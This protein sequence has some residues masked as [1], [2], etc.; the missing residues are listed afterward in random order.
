MIKFSFCKKY[1]EDFRFAIIGKNT[2]LNHCFGSVF[3]KFS[4]QSKVLLGYL[5]L[6]GASANQ[7]GLH[8]GREWL[9]QQLTTSI[10]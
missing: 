8:T 3:T 6:A 7:V 5:H 10:D 9:L 1:E 4:I 2:K